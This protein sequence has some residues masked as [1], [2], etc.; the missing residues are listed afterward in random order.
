MQITTYNFAKEPN[1]TK[2]PAS[3]GTVHNVVLKEPCS[4][5][6]PVFRLNGFSHTD[7]YVKWGSRY[8]FIEDIV[9]VTNSE[10]EYH[11][12][13]DVLATFKSY[14]GSSSQYIT[15]SAHSYTGNIIDGKYPVLSQ[16]T[17]TE[18]ILNTLHSAVRPS[19]STGFYV[20]GVQNEKGATSGGVTYYALGQTEMNSLLSFMF[21]GTW[22]D[23]SGQSISVALQ[24][25]L[26][27][28]MQYISSIVWFPFGS[29]IYSGFTYEEIKFGWWDASGVSGYRI[30]PGNFVQ[31]FQE[32]VS[33][34]RHANA[35]SRGIYLNGS[36]FTRYTLFC[37][38]FGQIAIDPSLFIDDASCLVSIAVD[39]STGDANLTIHNGTNGNLYA[40]YTGQMGTQ[41]QIA[42]MTQSLIG[43]AGNVVSGAV[44]IAYGN[45]V[46]YG[47]GIMSALDSLMPQIERSGSTGSRMWYNLAPRILTEHRNLASEDNAHLGRPLCVRGTVS[48]YPGFLQVENA[49]VDFA[50]NYAELTEIK[51]HLESGFYYE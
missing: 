36:P 46:G 34:P 38:T 41:I 20:V 11:C 23:S 2:Q 48:S 42:Q 24:K 49:D 16:I 9:Q 44:G 51:S 27:N 35:N 33:L 15:R 43:A 40:I 7:N 13:E 4:L 21:G 29:S 45:I 22:L 1:S 6:H 50:C 14:I 32:T 10:A 5:F 18:T 19:G 31:V 30:T 39:L 37:Y 28:P 8:Y 25:E 26:I 17:K 3:G 47:Q 12:R